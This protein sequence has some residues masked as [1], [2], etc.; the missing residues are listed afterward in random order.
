VARTATGRDKILMKSGGY[1]G[2]ADWAVAGSRN[3]GVPEPV[4]LQTRFFKNLKD[5]ENQ[6]ARVAPAALIIEPELTTR[7]ELAELRALCTLHD[8]ILIFDEIITGFRWGLS[9]AQG[10]HGVTPDL[11]CFG[12]SMAN[13]MPI[14]ALVGKRE[15]MRRF[16]PSDNCFVSGTFFGETLSIA[17]AL[18]TIEKMEKEPVHKHLWEQ[19]TLLADKVWDMLAILNLTDVIK[20]KGL[21]ILTRLEFSTDAIKALFIKE[22]ARHGVLILASHNLS[23]A[24]K[25]PE[26]KRILRAYEATL[27]T[28]SVAVHTDSVPKAAIM[29]SVRG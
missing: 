13:G 4:R 24:H 28:I 23:Y 27:K 10:H 12:K 1:H 20:L 7:E 3:I 19:G 29:P 26:M 21:P 9:G 14:S 16:A 15:I 11:A 18:A 6:I 17:A 5:A 2:W 8:I 22:M 25:A